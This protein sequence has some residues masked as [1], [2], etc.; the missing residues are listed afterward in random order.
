MDISPYIP[1]LSVGVTAAVTVVVTILTGKS[2]HKITAE[3]HATPSYTELG[4]RN[5]DL[6][7]MNTIKGNLIW[8]LEYRINELLNVIRAHNLTPPDEDTT[9]QSLRN[10]AWNNNKE[11]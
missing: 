4:S 2:N 11:I 6:E 7:R 8:R 9:L 1:V 5:S 3:E 10:Q